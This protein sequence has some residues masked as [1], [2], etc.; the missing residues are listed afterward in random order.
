MKHLFWLRP[1]LIAGRSGP[2]LDPW[3]PRELAAAGIGAVLS[4]NDASSVYV[5]DLHRAG[6]EYAIFPLSDN[7]P[8]RPGDFEHCLEMLPRACDYIVGVIERGKIPLV[9]CTAGKDRTGLILCHYLCHREGYEP[10]EAVAEVRRVRPIA[11]SA[12][13][14]EEFSLRVLHALQAGKN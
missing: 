4:V 1:R 6:L 3:D 14:Y 11:L 9:H 7:A 5:D 12:V 13:G 10:R 2:N 8:P